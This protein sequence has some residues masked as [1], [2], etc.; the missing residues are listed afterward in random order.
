MTIAMPKVNAQ[1]QL[2][3]TEHL[4]PLLQQLHIVDGDVDPTRQRGGVFA[5]R[6]ETGGEQHALGCQCGHGCEHAIQLALRHAFQPE[7]FVH[8]RAQNLRVR[9]GLD[10][11]EMPIQRRNGFQL[12]RPLSHGGQVIGIA[13]RA[14]LGTG[15]Q[16]RLRAGG[17][18][19][20]RW[21]RPEAAFNLAPTRA[22]HGRFMHR[23][24]AGINQG[25]VQL[26]QH[27]IGGGLIHHKGQVEVVGRLRNQVHALAPEH[28]PHILQFMQQ[29]TH[30]APDQGD[31][32]ARNNNLDPADA[33][34]VG[35]QRRQHV[36]I[37]QILGWIQ[38]HRHIGFGR[39]N[40]VYR[41]AMLLEQREHIG[42]EADLLPHAD[43][44]HRHQHDAIAAADRLHSRHR[45]GITVDAGARQLRALGIQNR[46]RH[47]A[48][49]A[50]ADRARVQ[51]FRAGGGNFLRLV[52]I[53]ARQQARIRHFTRV[54]AEH[55]GHVGP[56]FNSLGTQQRTEI[57]RRRI[58]T[59]TPQ[60]RGAPILVPGDEALRDQQARG[61]LR[62]ALAEITLGLC[63]A[64]DG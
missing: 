31:R 1:P 44:F 53:Q 4:W 62:K 57:R 18:P 37:D 11:I 34:K 47:A 19:P 58:R 3:A 49:A 9:V 10:R 42:E 27:A 48:V 15:Q 29:R 23:H 30:A 5:N 46:H 6:R 20:A 17:F 26:R 54:G 63:L 22:E 16:R 61:L 59:A 39:T 50:G 7:T 36:A 56:D 64:I 38:R 41:Q 13:R 55:A 51:H 2:A 35:R 52:I 32:R 8:Q 28:R 25:R 14:L 33:G 24:R 40:H 43:A 12:A 60:N 45:L 21:A